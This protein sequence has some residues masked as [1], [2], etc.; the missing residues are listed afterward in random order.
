MKRL[1]IIALLLLTL[2]TVKAAVSYTYTTPVCGTTTASFTNTSTGVNIGYAWYFGDPGSGINNVAVNFTK[3]TQSHTFSSYGTYNVKLYILDAT[4]QPID[5]IEHT[6]VLAAT[7]FLF[8][9]P[10]TFSDYCVGESINIFITAA[11]DPAY[12]YSWIPAPL[13]FTSPNSVEYQFTSTTTFT[14]V[15]TDTTTGCTNSISKTILFNNCTPITSQ[16]TFNPPPCGLLTV[17]FNNFSLAAHHYKWYFGDVASGTNDSLN[18]ADTSSVSHIFSDTGTFFVSL[19]VFDSLETKK[20]SSVK[21]VRL[22]K[23]S[24]AQIYNNDTTECIGSSVK[25]TG[26]GLGIAT[27]SPALGLSTTSGYTTV[28]KPQSTTTYYLTTNNNGCMATDSVTINIIMKPDPGFKAD[29]LCIGESFI[30]S[31]NTPGFT[32]YHWD[33]GTGDTATGS[34]VAYV[35]DTSGTYTVKLY[36]FNG[37][38][39]SFTT[40]KVVVLNNPIADFVP[41]KIKAEITKATFQFT[42]KSLYASSYSWDFGDATSTFQISPTHTYSDT[43][44]YDVIL[45]AFNSLGC[46]DTISMMIRVDNVYKYF[47]PSAF[48]P[49]QSGP[50]ENEVFKPFGPLGTTKFE[51]TIYDRWGQEVFTSIDER[52]PWDGKY[53]DGRECPNGNYIY[54]IR[55]KDPTGKRLIFNGIVTLYR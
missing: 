24:L 29:T 38:C 39:D 22:F 34:S 33:F 43:G 7:P 42:N 46:Q 54:V 32:Y 4:N 21:Q 5:S 51:M 50:Y 14:V 1:I 30:F 55:F 20:D 2:N 28:A 26:T 15:V 52:T 41:D 18:K 19:V 37:L 49:N 13:S 48:T 9:L 35:F 16:F 3:I 6:I 31:A 8:I 36:V 23:Q 17:N 11:N 47:V 10:N 40:M 53:S 12:K 44:W 45:T 25:L 27:W